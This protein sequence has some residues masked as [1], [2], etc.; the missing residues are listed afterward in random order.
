MAGKRCAHLSER[1]LTGAKG[2]ALIYLRLNREKYGW[3]S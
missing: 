1:L 3:K 2:V